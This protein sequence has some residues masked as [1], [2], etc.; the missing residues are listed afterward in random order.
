MMLL[1]TAYFK[2]RLSQLSFDSIS[3]WDIKRTICDVIVLV[4]IKL[5]ALRI[6]RLGEGA[7]V[8]RAT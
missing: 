3:K 5:K 6:A 2:L 4:T 7:V 8:V 1:L